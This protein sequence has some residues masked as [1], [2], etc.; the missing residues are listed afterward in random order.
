LRIAAKAVAYFVAATACCY[1]GLLT[2]W[3]L[4]RLPTLIALLDPDTQLWSRSI[5]GLLPDLR[6]LNVAEVTYAQVVI[7]NV[8]PFALALGV[9]AVCSQ[10]GPRL[11]H[12]N[13]LFFVFTAFWAGLLLIDGPLGFAQGISGPMTET[14]RL[15]A[16]AD[17][18]EP[19]FGFA[20][21]TLATLLVIATLTRI[22]GL[23]HL[24]GSTSLGSRLA[25]GALLF[26]A[27]VAA[28]NIVQGRAPFGSGFWRL[29]LAYAPT[30]IAALTLVI[31]LWRYRSTPTPLRLDP[32]GGATVLCLAAAAYAG[33]DLRTNIGPWR[34][35]VAQFDEHQSRY[36]DLRVEQG[37]FTPAQ[38][39]Q[40]AEDAD[41]RLEDLVA[42]L[43]VP[44]V[45]NK[46]PA[47][48]HTTT[49]SKRALAT[50]RR[51]DSPSFIDP[52]TGMLHHLV[53]VDGSLGDP[54][55]E[56]HML[57]RQAWGE[58]GSVNVAQAI[59]RYGAGRYLGYD[60]AEYARRITCE[61]RHYTLSEIC[62]LDG[63]YLSPIVSDV[64]SGAWVESALAAIE[65]SKR[66]SALRSLYQSTLSS[67]LNK[68]GARREQRWRTY[69]DSLPCPDQPDPHLTL[70]HNHKGITFTHEFRNGWGY[71]SDMAGKQLQHIRKLGGTAIALVP[72]ASFST[73]P[74]TDIRF[75]LSE[76]DERVVRSIDQAHAADLQ[77]MLKPQLWGRIFTGDI[78][79]ERTEDFEIWFQRYRRWI[80]HF[81]RMAELH[82]VELFCIGNE[83]NG[84]S[85]HE[86]HWRNLIRDVRRIYSGPLTFAANW[87]EEFERITFWDEL[88][89]LGVNFYF[90]L[91]ERGEIPAAGSPRLQELTA[92]LEAM[93]RR[94]RKPILFT[95][96][97]Y[98]PLATAAAEPWKETKAAFDHDLQKRCYE[99]V[100]Q[101]FHDKPWFTGMYWWKW[102]SHG[103][104]SAFSVGHNPIGKPALDVLRDWY[105]R[106]VPTTQ[107]K[108]NG[109]GS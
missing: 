75:R 35:A 102:P 36:W 99:T 26:V 105:S 39:Q 46:Y 70:H 31:A 56:A 94:Y 71:G 96:V 21:A 37:A 104:G 74:R 22:V 63:E 64:L 107:A 15:V 98:P 6:V 57:L 106:P 4:W 38:R 60:L 78:S 45:G 66:A 85:G 83:L 51:T 33:A 47:Y 72:Y 73:P 44:V 40:W 1:L 91:A 88:D 25:Y 48:I 93:H 79:Y 54:R 27:P 17:F 69:L 18:A 19:S 101:A 84:V 23:L 11:R 108:P 49:D 58:P 76:S 12:W 13:R 3:L 80:L 86:Q 32:L 28:L 9:V 77:V 103:Q 53:A 55:G 42:R 68:Q 30:L 8:G 61:E 34:Q 14:L 87:N 109:S 29:D 5:R 2:A 82:G 50:E 7:R 10:L 95:E 41:R 90:P 92:N 89:Y 24:E 100:F 81:A 65:P 97:G 59:A 62:A 20:L 52:S 67:I 43:A 16:L